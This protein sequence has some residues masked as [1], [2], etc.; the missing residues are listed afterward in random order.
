MDN[1]ETKQKNILSNNHETI[2]TLICNQQH[3]NYRTKPFEINTPSK[4]KNDNITYN[5]YNKQ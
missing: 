5:K 1:G 4:T 3:E 2:I